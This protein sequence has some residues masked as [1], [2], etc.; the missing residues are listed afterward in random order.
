MIK[1]NDKYIFFEDED[2]G[3]KVVNVWPDYESCRYCLENE[4]DFEGGQIVCIDAED[5]YYNILSD[6]HKKVF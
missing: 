6:W 3:C 2:T 4:E 1:E 5:F